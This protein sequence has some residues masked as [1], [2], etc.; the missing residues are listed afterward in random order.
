MGLCRLPINDTTFMTAKFN[1]SGFLF[2]ANLENSNTTDLT[3]NLYED[4]STIKNINTSFGF[5]RQI[6]NR[7][8]LSYGLS[9]DLIFVRPNSINFTSLLDNVVISELDTFQNQFI[10]FCHG[11]IWIM[12]F[13]KP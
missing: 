9:N 6:S 4:K 12:T 13:F 2:N 8:L 10:S 1:F 3:I 7:Y 5:D 11:C